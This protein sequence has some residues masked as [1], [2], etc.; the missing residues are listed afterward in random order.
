MKETDSR[1]SDEI[2]TD[3]VVDKVAEVTV[4][5]LK[6]SVFNHEIVS[7]GRLTAREKVDVNFQSPGLI[8]EIFVKN[9]QRVAK[10]Q[11]IATLDTYKLAN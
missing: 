2:T 1:I 3:T 9:G 5:Q 11:R 10:G 7:N 4:I 6:L 8:S